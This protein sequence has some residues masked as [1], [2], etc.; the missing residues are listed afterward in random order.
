MELIFKTQQ[1]PQ[2]A[3]V[4]TALMMEGTGGSVTVMVE[5][6]NNTDRDVEDLAVS[7][8][9]KDE[10][11]EVVDQAEIL[12]G[13]LPPLERRLLTFKFRQK[14]EDLTFLELR[15]KHAGFKDRQT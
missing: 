14:A 8:A 12:A 9:A 6:L 5:L 3:V 13:T 11:A 10:L 1:T 15:V 4:K 2:V 7:I